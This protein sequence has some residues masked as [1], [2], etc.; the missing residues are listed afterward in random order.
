M[1][2]TT[3]NELVVR[4]G[5]PDVLHAYPTMLESVCLYLRKFGRSLALPVVLCSSEM[6]PRETWDLVRAT[7][8][9]ELVDHYGQ[10]ERVAFAYARA[11]AS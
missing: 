1:S 10:A 5:V 6:L 3:N 9:A 11:P 4:S 7:M 2:V 8:R